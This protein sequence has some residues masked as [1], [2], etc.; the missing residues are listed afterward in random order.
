MNVLFFGAHPD[1]ETMLAGATLYLLTHLGHH[2]HV[3]SATRGEGGELGEP[4]VVKD[5]SLL[6]AARE[7]ELHDA[8]DVLGIQDLTFL[9]YIDPTIGEGDELYAFTDD[10]TV[11]EEKIRTIIIA[12][13]PD[14][15]L[16]HGSNGEYGHP[17]HIMVHQT[18]MDVVNNLPEFEGVVYTTA[19]QLPG[20]EDRIMNQDDPAHI[21][22]NIEP[23]LDVKL[24][25]AE[26]HL[27]Q[28][29]LFI[30]ATETTSVREALQ[31]RPVEP[32]HRHYPPLDGS[33]PDDV[34]AR[35]LLA[36]G[37]DLV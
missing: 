14:V 12:E 5:R 19:A 25:A 13:Q 15:I 4:P 21:V 28:N 6:G 22:L 1:D 10:R 8:C 18:V 7:S 24:Q 16:T 34:F 20:V 26:C 33:E 36:E 27:S 23:W 35:F 3:V 37:G 31:K 11:L 2:V 17:A 30:R 32:F 29:A 9:D